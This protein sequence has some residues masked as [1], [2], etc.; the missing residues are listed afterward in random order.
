MRNILSKWKIILVAILSINIVSLN[1]QVDQDVNLFGGIGSL[2]ITEIDSISFDEINDLMQMNISTD[3]GDIISYPLTLVDNVTFSGITSFGE[4]AEGYVHCNQPTQVVDVVSPITGRVWM[5]RNLGASSVASNPQDFSSFGDLYQ[6]GRF[7]D[8]HQC[9]NSSTTNVRSDSWHPNHDFFITTTFNSWCNWLGMNHAEQYLLDNG[10][11]WGDL[12]DQN[13]PCP[14]GYRI[15]TQAEWRVEI[16]AMD[17]YFDGPDV[18]LIPATP[19]LIFNSFLNLPSPGIRMAYDGQIVYNFNQVDP[20]FGYPDALTFHY[21]GGMKNV[22]SGQ[23][24]YVYGRSVRCIKEEISTIQSIDC[25]NAVVSSEVYATLPAAGLEITIPL[26]LGSAGSYEEQSFMSDGVQGLTAT[27]F[28]GYLVEGSDELTFFL[29]GIPSTE[30]LAS[31]DIQINGVSCT[32]AIPVLPYEPFFPEA[33]VHCNGPTEIV[34]V[35]NPT[36]G[37]VWMDRNLGATQ[38]ATSSDDEDAYGDLYQW[39]RFSDGHQCRNSGTTSELSITATPGHD[40]FILNPGQ[41]GNWMSPIMDSL[42]QGAYGLNNPCPSGYKVPSVAEIEAEISSWESAVIS[43]GFN[44]PLRWAAAGKRLYYGAINSVGS[45]MYY[46]TSTPLSDDLALHLKVPSINLPVQS[47]PKNTG[48]SVRCI[49]TIAANE[50]PEIGS[51]NC[52]EAEV[53]GNLIIGTQSD[54]MLLNIPYSGGNNGIHEGQVVESNGVTGITATLATNVL[55]NGEGVL[56]YVLTGTPSSTGTANFSIELAGQNCVASIEV[57]NGLVE[58][59]DCSDAQTTENLIEGMALS[60]GSVSVDYS[61]GNGGNY[62]GKTF[63]SSGVEGISLVL[64]EGSFSSGGGALVFTMTGTPTSYGIATFNIDMGGQQCVLE[65]VVFDSDCLSLESGLVCSD[66]SGRVWMDRNLGASQVASSSTDSNGYGHLY[67]WGRGSDGHQSRFSQETGST[68]STDQP[69]HGYFIRW[70]NENTQVSD[71]RDP[72]N[73]NL[74]QGE[75]GTNNPCPEGFRLPTK[76]EWELEVAG[77]DNDDPNAPFNSTLKL[78][79]AGRRLAG[80]GDMYH[81]GSR[82]YYWTSTPSTNGLSSC[83]EFF[84]TGNASIINNINNPRN[85]GLSVRCIKD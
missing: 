56:S 78:T 69:G 68:S 83:L 12:I 77:W 42:W 8:G 38:V 13:N 27:L 22:T 85:N 3:D 62:T 24:P 39:G 60:S 50:Y 4:Y 47:D 66:A 7:A 46:W 45:R 29:S 30:G 9:R 82:G 20:V 52:D 75:D 51:L 59:L 43:G 35:L 15:P 57:T 17:P 67:Q 41:T 54:G 55:A 1:A 72:S 34:D 84:T 26:T 6:P 18:D 58:S 10:A 19:S 11:T 48:M 73:D 40:L 53:V 61:N 2:P 37:K 36:T 70:P 33:T 23:G 64:S 79:M 21:Y 16:P 28:E 76:E 65:L 14:G 44:S 80:N 63:E 5:D 81:V 49:K 74:W 71:W 25:A 32:V 31:F